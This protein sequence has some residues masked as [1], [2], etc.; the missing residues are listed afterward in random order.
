MTADRSDL[1][2]IIVSFNTHD[3]LR[4]CLT[5]VLAEAASLHCEV[6]V[7]D[8][9]SGDGSAAM[10]QS[11]FPE[12]RLLESRVNLGFGAANNL[13]FEAAR[14]RFF[15]LLNS[16][17]FLAPGA[18]RLAVQHMENTPGCALGG[19]RLV[20]RDGEAQPSARA[21]HSLLGDGIVLTG[22][23]A[24]FPRSRFF[25]KFDRTWAD[26][27]RICEV[28]W[29]PGAFCI[30]RPEVLR[31]IGTFDPAFFLYYE[32]VDLCLRFKQ[33]GYRICYWPDVIVTHIGGESSRQLTSLDFST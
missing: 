16:D 9:A 30:I 18:L 25:G 5:G 33:A 15:V 22:L 4:E 32:E 13:A 19:G 1:S 26:Q 12:V 11:E 23:A 31:E 3:L 8:N 14:G 27:D 6:L 10:V 20:G 21:F 17:A 29:V 2:I 7:V 28:D 24:K